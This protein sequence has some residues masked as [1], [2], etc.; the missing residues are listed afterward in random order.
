MNVVCCQTNIVWENKSKNFAAAESMLKGVPAGS[1]VLLPEMF[2][3]GFSMNVPAI[4]ETAAGETTEFLRETARKFS[5]YL[6]GGVV[7]SGRDGRGLNQAV[8]MSPAGKEL[9]RYSKMQPFSLGGE[10][11]HYN[12]GDDV[13]LFS[14]EGVQVAPFICYDL[15]FPEVFRAAVRKGAELFAVIANW[16][17]ARIHHWT[18]L[19]RARAIENQAFVAGTNRCGDDPKLKYNGRSLIVNQHGDILAEADDQQQSISSEVDPAAIRAWRTD[20]PA[21]QDM[22][23]K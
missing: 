4:A 18:I 17:V 23:Q 13:V 3:T 19:L 7:A 15:R 1:L 21:L 9:A 12:A 5:I 14:W 2:A 20:F 10:A 16:P 8:V 6:M 11:K 22:R